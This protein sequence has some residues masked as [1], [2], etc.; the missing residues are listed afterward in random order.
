MTQEQLAEMSGMSRDAIS[1]IE[2]D[3]RSPQGGSLQNLGRALQVPVAALLEDAAGSPAPVD[4][5]SEVS[6]LLG[7]LEPERA[8]LVVRVVRLL[9]KELRS[10][11]RTR[12][13]ERTR[14]EAVPLPRAAARA[15]RL[16]A[17]ARRQTKRR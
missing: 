3:D 5:A 12:Q 14:I 2:R 17:A 9:V 10:E 4:G 8:R 7:Q 15:P 16:T 13:G 6:A 11:G 1:R